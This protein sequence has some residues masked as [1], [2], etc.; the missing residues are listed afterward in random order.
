MLKIRTE[1]LKKEINKISKIISIKNINGLFNNVFFNITNDFIELISSDNNVYI[2]TIIK[3]EKEKLEIKAINNFYVNLKYLNDILNKV[4]SEYI[5][6]NI[7]DNYLIL[8]TKNYKFKLIFNNI[9][10]EQSNIIKKDLA[11][12]NINKIEYIKVE[13]SDLIY[14]FNKTN[15]SIN[16]RENKNI[17]KGFNFIF[18]ENNIEV[19]T[20]DSY[21]L[22]HV[23]L[24]IDNNIKKNIIIPNKIIN[25]LIK[26]LSDKNIKDVFININNNNILFKI[27]NTLINSPLIN[28]KYIDINK[29]L[30]N[31]FNY[32]IEINK[33]NLI[34][35]ISRITT[36]ISDP[37][38]LI[39]K[40]KIKN[41]KLIIESND[42]EIGSSKEILEIKNNNKKEI[43]LYLNSIF[44]N[45]AIKSINEENININIIDENKPLIINSKND[46]KAIQLIL[47][48]KI[49]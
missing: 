44:L 3:S 25:D 2:K 22:S 47:P 15:F 12:N 45:D 36:I 10:D 28:D 26:L 4:D 1:I 18:D 11:V 5:N 31:E 29:I 24:K 20:T 27:E 34:K 7:Q 16:P 9:T 40:L 38:K 8:S 13:S 41:D 37:F 32:L 48:I 23:K 42:D 33:K 35:S 19:N 17:L 21:R 30:P 39:I 49:F 46:N 14:L 43:D 6:L